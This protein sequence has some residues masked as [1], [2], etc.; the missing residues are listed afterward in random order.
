MRS[1]RQKNKPTMNALWRHL[2]KFISNIFPFVL[3]HRAPH[4]VGQM[5]LAAHC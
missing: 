4:G 3:L 5:T 2:L 1:L